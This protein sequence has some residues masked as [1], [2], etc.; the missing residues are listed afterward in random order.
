LIK[1]VERTKIVIEI[2]WAL[3]KKNVLKILRKDVLKILIKILTT[4][5]KAILKTRV[6]WIQNSLIYTSFFFSRFNL[7]LFR[8]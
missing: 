6:L 2:K 1:E 8:R 7:E 3:M 4:I 5:L